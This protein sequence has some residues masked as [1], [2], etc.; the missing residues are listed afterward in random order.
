MFKLIFLTDKKTIYKP[1]FFIHK[2]IL[3]NKN[4]NLT[5]EQKDILLNKTNNVEIINLFNKIKD[6]LLQPEKIKRSMCVEA[7]VNKYIHKNDLYVVI[8]DESFK[9]ENLNVCDI[10][11]NLF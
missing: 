6:C 5:R 11:G 8:S 10:K 4:Y 9:I 3:N 1:E 7:Y 2:S